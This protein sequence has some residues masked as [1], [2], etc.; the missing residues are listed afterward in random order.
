MQ[1]YGD[2]RLEVCCYKIDR[3]FEWNSQK[4]FK[5]WVFQNKLCTTGHLNGFK[6][7]GL[8]RGRSSLPSTSTCFPSGRLAHTHTHRQTSHI[9]IYVCIYTTIS[10]TD[11]SSLTPK[12]VNPAGKKVKKRR[13]DRKQ[14]KNIIPFYGEKRR[15]EKETIQKKTGNE[16]KKNTQNF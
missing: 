9:Y 8:K 3:H 5:T 15:G 13:G 16:E 14:N 7:G 2:K 4:L 1:R 12:S 6:N 10:G 11:G